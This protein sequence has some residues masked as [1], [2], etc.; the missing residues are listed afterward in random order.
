MNERGHYYQTITRLFLEHRGAPFFLS[1]KEIDMIAA[2]E[3]KGIP[4]RV[5]LNGIR[6]SFLNPK[7]RP[8]RK[9]KLFTL[10][11]CDIYVLNA[12][13]QYKEKKVG[14]K[15]KI[16]M[17]E[18]RREK[19]FSEVEGFLETIPSSWDDL[20]EAFKKV[21][22]LLCCEPFDEPS[23]EDWEEKIEDLIFQR[24]SSEEKEKIRKEVFEEYE[25]KE[26]DEFSRIFRIKLIRHVRNQHKIPYVSP[27][28]Y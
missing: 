19:I 22:G 6:D 27:F 10:A 21:H 20:E 23:L 24:A 12:F 3:K 8:G 13:S 28:Y 26:G 25:I 15:K 9:G 18:N 14:Q 5:V 2:W 16:G 11:F 7:A 1:A 17:R 4:L